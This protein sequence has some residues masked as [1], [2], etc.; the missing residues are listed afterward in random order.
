MKY[1]IGLRKI[2]P[3]KDRYQEQGTALKS[4]IL[5]HNTVRQIVPGVSKDC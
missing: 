3:M 5:G 4:S 2:I 1:C